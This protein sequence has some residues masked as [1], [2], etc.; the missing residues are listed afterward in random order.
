MTE[1]S[2]RALITGAT[3]T[4]ATAAFGSMLISPSSLI[5]QPAP[6]V[7]ADEN[8]K[9]QFTALSAS[10]TGID[11]NILSPPVDTA[12]FRDAVFD[13]ANNANNEPKK[14]PEILAKLLAKFNAAKNAPPNAQGV[15]TDPIRKL[16]EDAAKPENKDEYGPMMFL[17]RSIILA[18][19]LGAWYK[20]NDLKKKSDAAKD[21]QHSY[22]SSRRYSQEVL[23]PHEIISPGTYTNSMVWRVAQAHPMGY[24]NLQFGYWEKQPPDISMFTKAIP[25][26]PKPIST[27]DGQK[28]GSK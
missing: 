18:W 9:A 1:I 3:A 23:I 7:P 25:A 28:A 5:A 26:P 22:Y 13:R 17:M 16:Y 15:K 12:H 19:Y 11:E 20:P 21:P 6:A 10:L 27:P 24:S 8:I 4:A 2:R 14:D